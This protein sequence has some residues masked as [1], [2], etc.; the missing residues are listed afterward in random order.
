MLISGIKNSYQNLNAYKKNQ[1][2]AKKNILN[3]PPAQTKATSIPAFN[4]FFFKKREPEKY[5]VNLIHNA[6]KTKQ[7]AIIEKT[8]DKYEVLFKLYVKEKEAGWLKMSKA[9]CFVE[10]GYLISEPDNI[11]PKITGFRTGTS[12]TFTGIDDSLLRCAIEES[13]K[14]GKLGALWVNAEVVKLFEVNMF[15]KKQND[16]RKGIQYYCSRG[17]VHPY[18][19]INK[20]LMKALEEDRLDDIKGEYRL[21]LPSETAQKIL[22]EKPI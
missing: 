1:T 21:L 2:R 16:T 15:T 8:E 12:G 17:F 5:Q 3:S 14:C 10:D 20:K 22:N 18:E 19:P 11:L 9:E 13:V 7:P 4:G 6:T